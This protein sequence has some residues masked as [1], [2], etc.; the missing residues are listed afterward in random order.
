MN[1]GASIDT[2]KER[3]GV[4][5]PDRNEPIETTGHEKATAGIKC[6]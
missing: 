3:A 2:V 4:H 6:C 5:L 1:R